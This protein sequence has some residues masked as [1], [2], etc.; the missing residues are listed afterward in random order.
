MTNMLC[1]A[2]ET[3]VALTAI[4]TNRYRRA[5]CR[6]IGNY[7]S[8]NVVRFS[9]RR[10]LVKSGFDWN[11]LAKPRVEYTLYV[12]INRPCTRLFVECKWNCEL[13]RM[14]VNQWHNSIIHRCNV[15]FPM[16]SSRSFHK[17]Y[18]TLYLDKRCSSTVDVS[19][20]RLAILFC[21]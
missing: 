13:H 2:I 5:T 8:A 6:C 20:Q 9:N 16:N 1:D 3:I 19:K 17:G 12:S 14:L 10:L 21:V 18:H 7:R 11:P 4:D 15:V